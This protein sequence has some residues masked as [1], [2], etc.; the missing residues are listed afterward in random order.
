MI[1]A[2]IISSAFAIGGLLIAV[3]LPEFKKFENELD[4]MINK[5]NQ[6]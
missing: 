4:E 5:F 6:E 3:I 2:L 1:L